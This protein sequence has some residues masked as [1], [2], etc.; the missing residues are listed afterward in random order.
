MICEPQ[1]TIKLIKNEAEV[2][3]ELPREVIPYLLKALENADARTKNEIENKIVKIGKKAV[4]IIVE[5][6]ITASPAVKGVICMALIR[7]GKDS[8][9]PLKKAAKLNLDL[10]WVADYL[11]NEIEGTGVPL[12]KTDCYEVLAV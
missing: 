9:N 4:D 2:E 10:G 12:G 1:N 8:I 6:L 5:N 7:I 11:I 3:R